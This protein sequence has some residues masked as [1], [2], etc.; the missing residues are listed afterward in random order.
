MSRPMGWRSKPDRYD[1]IK[2]FLSQ[3]GRLRAAQRIMAV[4]CAFGGLGAVERADH[5]AR[6]AR[7]CVSHWWAHRRVQRRYDLLL[8]DTLANASAVRDSRRGRGAVYRSVESYPVHRGARRS[9]LH[10][11]GR[12]GGLQRNIPP[13]RIVLFHG[14]VSGA[15]V[16]AAVARLAN[17]VSIAAAISAFWLI[18]FVNVSVLLAAW[19]MSRAREGTSDDLKRMRSP[20]A[21]SARVD[22]DGHQSSCES[23]SNPHPPDGGDARS[24]QVQE[25]QRH[26]WSF[27]R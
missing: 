1:W 25:H 27:G 5:P 20:T 10:S 14:V 8:S 19:G 15:I 13:P 12:H 2:T 7:S 9:S 18:N 11:H 26:P 6:A 24:R 16:L 17:E 21:Q 23:T 22:R 3:R 4:V